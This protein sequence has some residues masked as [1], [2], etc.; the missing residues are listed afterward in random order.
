MFSKGPLVVLQLRAECDD[1][2]REVPRLCPCDGGGRTVALSCPPALDRRYLGSGQRRAGVASI[3]SSRVRSRAVSALRAPVR[4][5]SIESRAARSEL[6]RR[7]RTAE[8]VDSSKLPR[9]AVD[10]HSGIRQAA[11][12]RAR[13]DGAGCCKTPRCSERRRSGLVIWSVNGPIDTLVF[14]AEKNDPAMLLSQH[15]PVRPI[16][17]RMPRRVTRP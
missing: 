9:L 4:W 3:S 15:T 12:S 17:D 10:N 5:V 11:G 1:G 14:R 2:G 16:D 8:L 13:S 6:P 7:F